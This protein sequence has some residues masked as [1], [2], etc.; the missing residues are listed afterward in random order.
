LFFYHHLNIGGGYCPQFLVLTLSVS[1]AQGQPWTG[2]GGAATPGL[3][4]P[5]GLLPVYMCVCVY[6]YI[7]PCTIL[8]KR[9]R[10]KPTN[11]NVYYGG[12][13]YLASSEHTTIQ[14]LPLAFSWKPPL[15]ADGSRCPATQRGNNRLTTTKLA[16]TSRRPG[17]IARCR[18]A[19][20]SVADGSVVRLGQVCCASHLALAA[21]TPDRNFRSAT[22]LPFISFSQTNPY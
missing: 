3:Q 5:G 14:L 4:E 8:D 2:A 18:D 9:Q 15:T 12:M 6:I 11:V 21:T 19:T 10:L 1:S 16:A 20:L 13:W 7:I 17:G 22:L